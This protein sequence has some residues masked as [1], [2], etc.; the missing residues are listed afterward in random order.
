MGVVPR[1]RL[2]RYATLIPVGSGW[3]LAS[4]VHLQRVVLD[5]TLTPFCRLL[6][7]RDVNETDV[8]AVCPGVNAPQLLRFLSQRQLIVP[9]GSNEEEALRVR[10]SD[11]QP[12]AS[13]QPDVPWPPATHYWRPQPLS[14]TD[15]APGSD[16]MPPSALRVL[17]IGGCVLQFTEDTLI[18]LGLER[19]YG[20]EVRHEWPPLSRPASE[21]LRR[22]DPALTVLQPTIQPLLSGLWDQGAQ[23]TPSERRE[24]VDTLKGALAAAV[25]EL[26]KALD[27]RLGLIHNV[28]PPAVSPFG[29]IDFRTPVSFRRIVAEINEHIDEVVAEH[30]NLMV[31]DEER[32]AAR[33]GAAALFDELTLPFGHHGGA[34]DLSSEQLLPQPLLGTV[35]AHEYLDCYQLQHGVN[36]VRCII[37]DL[38]GM[39]WP[40]IAADTGFGW[41]DGDGTDRWIRLGLHQALQVLKHRGILLAASSK[42]TEAATLA[43][44]REARHPLLL[45]PDDFVSLQINWRPK[46]EAVI[47]LC[48]QLG[49]LPEQVVFLDDSPVERAEMRWR[50]PAIRVPE[51]PVHALRE[52]LLTDPCFEVP[53]LTA[54]A[55]ARSATTKAMLARKADGRSGNKDAFL[56]ALEVKLTVRFAAVHEVP[57]IAELL[58][59]VNQFTTTGLRLTESEAEAR[60]RRDG[61]DLLIASVTDKYADYGLVG[62][63]LIEDDVVSALVISCRV[64]GLDIAVPFLV[65]CLRES[66]RDR[67]GIRGLVVPTPRNE[68]ARDVFIRAGFDQ[69]SPGTYVLAGRERLPAENVFRGRVAIDVA[70]R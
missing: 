56:Q 41:L 34:P 42:G 47:Q 52:Y 39:L 64:I 60:V 19:G 18:K 70:D 45:S 8:T 16:R 54:E 30:D 46:A 48:N 3:L 1:F 38:D 37:T 28:A 7:Q 21:R 49:L 31:L 10:L 15:F 55:G 59:R 65:S 50:L 12:A 17:L 2:S 11:L 25:A 32:L 63:C 67:E 5:R 69:V 51:L 66:D 62:V 4:G 13:S 40:G 27:G 53:R 61:T 43:V 29:R 6:L 35:L 20:V 44:W 9:D 23:A 33:H 14:A 68:P 22:W 58:N 36:Q 26:A 24:R 57:R